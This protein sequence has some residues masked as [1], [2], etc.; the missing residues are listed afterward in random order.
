MHAESDLPPPTGF[1]LAVS[2]PLHRSKLD[3][4][5]HAGRVVAALRQAILTG[6]YPT[7]APLIESR[8]AAEFGV[9]RGPVRSAIQILEAEGLIHSLPNG[10][11]VVVGLTEDDI[12]DLFQVRLEMEA[13]AIRWG[14]ERSRGL[15]GVH[16]ALGAM[17]AEGQSTPRL[18]QLDMDFHRA[19]CEFSG[20]RFLARSWGALAPLIEALI[21]IGNRGLRERDPVSDF[22]RIITAHEPLVQ[23]LES[24]DADA[25]IAF[26]SEQFELTKRMVQQVIAAGAL[27]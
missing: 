25:A 2:S 24:G 21:I 19:L 8:V 6:V 12:D 22:E 5:L 16:A 27:Q 9:S 20:S 14:L 10:R 18:V 1:S 11:T 15:D 13:T 4:S 26:L 17:R 7:E 3:R 23:A